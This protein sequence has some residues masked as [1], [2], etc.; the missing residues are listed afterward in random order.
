MRREGQLES[1]ELVQGDRVVRR[2]VRSRP[3]DET[4]VEILSGLE[5]GET[6]VVAAGGS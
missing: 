6:L 1:V 2:L 3:F 5:G 4:R